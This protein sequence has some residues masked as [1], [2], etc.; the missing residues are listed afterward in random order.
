MHSNLI[1]VCAWQMPSMAV[2]IYNI[3]EPTV[4]WR[5]NMLEMNAKNGFADMILD[6]LC[7]F[8]EGRLPGNLGDTPEALDTGEGA[9]SSS[10]VEAFGRLFGIGRSL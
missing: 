1:A 9:G 8:G 4:E 7:G 3:S 10:V 6:S 5:T 2:L